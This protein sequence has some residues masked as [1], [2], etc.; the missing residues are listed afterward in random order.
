MSAAERAIERARALADDVGIELAA[1]ARRLDG[2]G[3][4]LGS[5]PDRPVAIASL[6]KLPLAL[7]WASSGHDP[8]GRL[9]LASR[10]RLPGP[11]GVS[12]LADD[13]EIS[14]RD[15]VRLMLSVSDNA[16]AEALL[17]V[18]G[19][20]ALDAWIADAGAT[21]TVV[22]RGAEE[23]WRRVAADVGGRAE[24]APRS[25]A[26]PDVDVTTAE[27]DPALASVSTPRDLVAMLDRA[28]SAPAY[29][30]VRESMALQAWRHRIGSGF[31]HDDVR[32]FGKTGSLGRLRHEVG[33]VEY[34][35]E[36]PVAVAVLTTSV[37]P[38]THQ[39]RVDR[40]IGE[41]ARTLVQP[42]RRPVW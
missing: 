4:E 2:S 6:Y 12:A 8:R 22:R 29:A 24:A 33:V 9:R 35:A 14:E 1:I 17:G 34:P 26:D 19:H 42:L 15:A 40:A 27:Y 25:L 21:A 37:R 32:V 16:A 3:D 5:D 41:I 36:H 7:A 13:V 31:P 23:S 38:E 10:S 18:V 39:P 20:A 28:W 30:W 11:T